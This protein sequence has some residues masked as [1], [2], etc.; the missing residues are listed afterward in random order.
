MSG[1]NRRVYLLRESAELVFLM[2]ILGVI[3]QFSPLPIWVWF[4]VPLGK[5]LF[6]SVM[7]V[8]FLRKVL[9][10]RPHVGPESL[11]G[12]IAETVTPLD[13]TGQIRINGEIWSA[14]SDSGAMIPGRHK[15]EIQRV[16]GNTAHVVDAE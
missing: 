12:E 4:G 16:E 6:S 7:Y 14:R 9:L 1:G 5:I 10:R 11:L 13:P 2:I 8:F 15:V 3:A